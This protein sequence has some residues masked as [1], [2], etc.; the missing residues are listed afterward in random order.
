MDKI[1]VPVLLNES[2]ESLDIKPNGFYIDCTLGDGGHSYEIFRKLSP[3][4]L[5]VSIDQDSNAIDFVKEYYKDILS[6]KDNWKLENT[7]FSKIDKIASKYDRKPDG[8]FMDLGFSSRQLEDSKNRGFSYQESE[9]PLDM[10]M[11]TTLAV[12]A[13]DL[14][15]VLTEKDLSMI[16]KRYGEERYANKIAHA[17]KTSDKPIEKVGDLTKL[18]YETIPAESITKKNPS[19]RVF[20]ALRIVVND[21]LHS[22]EYGLDKSFEILNENGR[23]SVITFHSLEDRI[24]KWFFNNKVKSGRG[25]LLF[26]KPIAPT[27]EEEKQNPRSTSAKLRT[28]IKN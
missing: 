13:A 9:E 26:T 22:L 24:V 5:L 6:E 16:F 10:R 20:Q 17:I 23:L 18:I 21:E 15:K 8:I 19:R 1:H 12:T 14:L 7:N 27:D 28:I 2:L 4:G 3:D 11:D 25:V